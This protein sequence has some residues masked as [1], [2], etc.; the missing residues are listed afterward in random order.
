MTSDNQAVSEP[1]VEHT[2]SANGAT[3]L[4]QKTIEKNEGMY[5]Q[6]DTNA[7]FFTSCCESTFGGSC[8]D[9]FTKTRSTL[10][11]TPQR[12]MFKVNKEN[13]GGVAF[14]AVPKDLLFEMH[15]EFAQDGLIRLWSW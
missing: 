12:H 10:N 6:F 9:G 4:A 11:R 2:H 7:M 14:S 3:L 13:K 8:F 1:Q 5:K 15:E